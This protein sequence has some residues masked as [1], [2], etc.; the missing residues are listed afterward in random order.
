MRALLGVLTAL[1]L[2]APAAAQLQPYEGAI[3]EHTAYSDGE[4]G[5]R[6]S[7]AFAAVRERGSDFM[8]STEHSDTFELPIG[9]TNTVCLSERLPECAIADHQE[10]LNSV[11]RWGAIRRQT[12]AA[13]DADFVGIRGFEWTN[14]RHG[15]LNVLFS[16][17]YTN[18]KRDGAYLTM[19]T[20]WSW[21]TRPV[22]Q[23]GGADGLGIFNHPGRRELGEIL[24]GGFLEPFTPPLAQPGSDW[25]SFAYRPEADARMVG[26]E[27]FNGGSDYGDADDV[28]PAGSYGEALD[29]GWHVGA[30]G[31][32]DTHD[33][34]WGIP[35]QRKTVILAPE[36]TRKALRRA[37]KARRFYAVHHAGVRMSFTADGREM[38][39]RLRRAAGQVVALRADTDVPGATLELVTSGGATVASGP[40]PLAVDRPASAGERWYFV[41]VRGADG[42]SVAYSSP[43]W[44]ELSE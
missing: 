5:Q 40:S 20:F 44:V 12:D 17:N 6:P 8:A 2:A 14:D 19:E 24:P 28:H 38:G 26:M 15:H 21:F 39:R 25:D 16:R 7:D 3:H 30:I 13:T 22:S 10:P 41:R 31:A 4:P 1:V 37:M 11:H 34:D 27:L 33:T 23:G 9:A 42:K 35:S 43:V 36:L 29:A 18:A 32:E